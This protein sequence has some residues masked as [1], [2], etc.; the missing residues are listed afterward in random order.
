MSTLYEIDTS[1]SL[2]E[3]AESSNGAITVGPFKKYKDYRWVEYRGKGIEVE[4]TMT[5]DGLIP[6]AMIDRYDSAYEKL[7]RKIQRMFP[8]QFRTRYYG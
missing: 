6:V 3:I 8:G 4:V 2:D 7:V 1:L 5:N